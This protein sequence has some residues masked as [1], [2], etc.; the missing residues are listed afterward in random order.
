MIL[1]LI[2]RVI[3]RASRFQIPS[4]NYLPTVVVCFAVV[5]VEVDVFDEE[6]VVVVVWGMFVVVAIV[7]L[8]FVVNVLEIN[9]LV[10]EAAVVVV[11][12]DMVALVPLDDWVVNVVDEK[13]FFIVLDVNVDKNDIA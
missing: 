6:E 4:K 10:D 12:V 13:L 11:L 2:L 8:R 5:K 7:M 9:K 3:L 1:C